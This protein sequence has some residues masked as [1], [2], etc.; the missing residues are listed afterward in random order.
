MPKYPNLIWYHKNLKEIARELRNSPTQAGSYLWE[1]LK[2]KQLRGYDFHRQKS[3]LY[4]IVDFYC[5]K[6]KLAIELDGSVHELEEIKH[7][8]VIRQEELEE[9]GIT[10]L[11]FTNSDVLLRINEVLQAIEDWIDNRIRDTEL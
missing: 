8:D 2:G 6:M 4:Y 9:H 3:L 5:P 10:F 7:R 11:R 1:K